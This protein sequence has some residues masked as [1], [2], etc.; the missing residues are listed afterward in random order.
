MQMLIL[1][2]V[3][4]AGVAVF[5]YMKKPAKKK[6]GRNKSSSRS[7]PAVSQYSSV[8]IMAPKVCCEAAS[9]LAGSKFL[10]KSAPKLPLPA[11]DRA[12]CK[13]G[14]MHHKDRRD[15]DAD[16]RA[17]YGMRSELHAL[18]TGKERR[19]HRGRRA[20]DFAMA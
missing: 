19:E 1:V 18:H 2:A 11:C 10:V 15:E 6:P 17:M 20:V 12:G 4:L 16:R 5:L 13:C 7:R 9:D 3:L 14:Y 8:S